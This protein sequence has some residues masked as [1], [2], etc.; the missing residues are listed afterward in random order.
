M[1]FLLDTNILSKPLKTTPNRGIIFD[2]TDKQPNGMEKNKTL[3]PSITPEEQVRLLNLLPKDYD[4]DGSKELIH[5]I[6]TSHANKIR[7]SLGV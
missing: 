2:E 5:I 4:P 7:R 1:K 6:A 3:L